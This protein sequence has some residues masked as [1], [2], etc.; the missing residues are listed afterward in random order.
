VVLTQGDVTL[1]P[2]RVS[3]HRRWQQ[4]RADNHAWLSEWDAT[5]PLPSTDPPPTFRNSARR[6]KREAKRGSYLPFVVEYKGEFVGQINVADIVYGS[7]R[8]C[9]IGYWI[10]QR[11]AGRG[12]MTV[13]LALVTDYLF[14]V[15]RLHRIEIGIRPENEPSN[16]LV[17]RVGY[18]YE[19]TREQFLHIN[20]AWR[21]HHIYAL[22]SDQRPQPLAPKFGAPTSG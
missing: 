19:G 1:R 15:V 16:R 14:D 7:L 20:N 2:L 12:I 17:R 22:R 6:M 4:L 11:V 3:D 13:A 10:S 5:A 18:I 8:G 9:H 21:D